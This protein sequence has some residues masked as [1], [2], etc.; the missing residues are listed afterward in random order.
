MANYIS[1]SMCLDDILAKA[2]E[3]H[4]AFSRANNGKVYFNIVAWMND[5]KDKFDNNSSFM[6][7]SKKENQD[8]EGKVYIGNGRHNLATTGS[9]LPSTN[10]SLTDDLPF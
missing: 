8:K 5:E 4:S 2:K 10:S 7:S 1:G 9:N 6:L 3:G